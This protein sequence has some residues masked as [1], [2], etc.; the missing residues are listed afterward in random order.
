MQEAK[1]RIKRWFRFIG[2][3]LKEISWLKRLF[4]QYN[5]ANHIKKDT[6]IRLETQ[7]EIIGKYILNFTIT[8]IYC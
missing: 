8:L 4:R 2:Q 7:D 3:K 6:V 1:E 5:D